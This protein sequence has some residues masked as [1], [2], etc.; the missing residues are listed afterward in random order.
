M[1]TRPNSTDLIT[2]ARQTFADTLLP[3]MADKYRYT[4]LMVANALANAERELACG[5]APLR[6]ELER[7]RVL[8]PSAP[9]TEEP[10]ATQ[11]DRINRRLAVDIR[12]GTFLSDRPRREQVRNHLVQTTMERVR[13]TN[14]KYLKKEGLE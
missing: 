5:D 4:A 8:Y 9:A 13:E 11:L 12:K 3:E 7:L 10:L 6:A 14:P 1:R 2:V